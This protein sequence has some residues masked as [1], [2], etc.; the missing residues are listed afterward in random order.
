LDQWDQWDQW[1]N[2]SHNGGKDTMG[3]NGMQWGTMGHI[4]AHWA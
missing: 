1:D 4:G 3:H 2:E